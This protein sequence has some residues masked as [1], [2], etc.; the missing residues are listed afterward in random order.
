MI[1]E[2]ARRYGV[3][4]LGINT[5]LCQDQ[6]DSVVEWMCVGRWSKVIDYGE[7]SAADTGLPSMPHWFNDNRDFRNIREGLEAT[8]FSDADIDV[9][10]GGQLV[11]VL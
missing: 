1:E 8:S 3:Q 10:T 2:A 6:P 9:I 4:N 5:D 7:G 11:A